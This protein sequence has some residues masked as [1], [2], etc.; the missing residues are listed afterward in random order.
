MLTRVRVGLLELGQGML[1]DSI[2]LFECDLLRSV[3]LGEFTE[4]T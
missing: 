4:S 1:A 2:C 3:F